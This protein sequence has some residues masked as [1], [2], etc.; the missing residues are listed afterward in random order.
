MRQLHKTINQNE[1]PRETDKTPALKSLVSMATVDYPPYSSPGSDPYI[2]I[3]CSPTCKQ[4]L[5]GNQYRSDY[6]VISVVVT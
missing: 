4:Q 5:A 2:T 3:I 6:D 1:M